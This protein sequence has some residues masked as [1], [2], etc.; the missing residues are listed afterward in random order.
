M[1]FFLCVRGYGKV[2]NV[3]EKSGNFEVDD[4]WQPCKGL[5]SFYKG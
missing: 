1:I 2:Q 3:R 4:K 5:D